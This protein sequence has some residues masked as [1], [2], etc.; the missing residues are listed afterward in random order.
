MGASFLVGVFTFTAGICLAFRGQKVFFSPPEEVREDGLSEIRRKDT[1][2]VNDGYE[3]GPYGTDNRN[4]Y[5]RSKA[6]G[7]AESREPTAMP[8]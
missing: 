2:E 3:M 8:S 6:D 1:H 7:L 4:A 5:D